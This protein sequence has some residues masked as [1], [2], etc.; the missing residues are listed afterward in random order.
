MVDVMPVHQPESFGRGNWLQG[1]DRLPVR[2]RTARIIQRPGF[3][4]GSADVPISQEA[5]KLTV[6]RKKGNRAEAGLLLPCDSFTN[7]GGR[8]NRHTSKPSF[9]AAIGHEK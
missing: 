4:N 9:K 7:G 2:D 8:K 3:E 6:G 5:G 1:R